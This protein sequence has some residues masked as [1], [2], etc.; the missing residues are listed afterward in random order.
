MSGSE[1][2]P[3]TV[4]FAQLEGAARE[5]EHPKLQMGTPTFGPARSPVSRPVIASVKQALVSGEYPRKGPLREAALDS[6]RQETEDGIAELVAMREELAR[7]L[8]E[9][10]RRAPKSLALEAKRRVLEQSVVLL[11]QEI[12]SL[13]LVSRLER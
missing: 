4:S 11:D 3:F 1:K 13:T 7:A 5:S 8:E 6:P 2:T 9:T 12:E 10:A